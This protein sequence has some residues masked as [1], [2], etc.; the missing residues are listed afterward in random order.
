[1]TPLIIAGIRANIESD[2]VSL[3]EKQIS[4]PK[5]CV[6]GQISKAAVKFELKA[7]EDRIKKH[8]A[9]LK[10]SISEYQIQMAH[11]PAPPRQG[12]HQ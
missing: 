1:M 10:R 8:K 5:L 4:L 9:D 6:S 3:K 7:I 11:R 2:E 12:A